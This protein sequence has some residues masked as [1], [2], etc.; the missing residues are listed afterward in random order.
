MSL[1]LW[2]ANGWLKLHVTDVQELR[3]LLQIA[4]RD[5]ADAASGDLSKGCCR[6]IVGEI[7]R[8]G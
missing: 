5:M 1:T 3:N 6:Q 2:R 8:F 4:D 7:S